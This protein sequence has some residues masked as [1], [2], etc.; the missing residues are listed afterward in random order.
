MSYFKTIS[1]SLNSLS[2][3]RY[4]YGY[5]HKIIIPCSHVKYQI[6]GCVPDHPIPVGGG[7][8]NR[9]FATNVIY[10]RYSKKHTQGS[11]LVVHCHTLIRVSFYH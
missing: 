11:C 1:R 5:E 4:E 10:Q 8:I 3:E 6:A 2:F 9:T 7:C